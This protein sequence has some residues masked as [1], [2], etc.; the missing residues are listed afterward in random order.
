[1]SKMCVAVFLIVAGSIPVQA[2]SKL[3]QD[4][5]QM[6]IQQSAGALSTDIQGRT[7]ATGNGRIGERQTREQVAP[8]NR[9][10]DRI[11]SRIASRIDSRLRTRIDR[12]YDPSVAIKASSSLAR[13]CTNACN[14]VRN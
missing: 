9:P 10:L 5:D 14:P 8:D 2:K 13:K 11:Q 3:D 4:L 12:N 6:S 1:M 7:A